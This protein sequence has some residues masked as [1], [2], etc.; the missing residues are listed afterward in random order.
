MADSFNV[1]EADLAFI[2]KQIKVSEAETDAVM[3]GAPADEALRAI[4]GPNAAILPAGLRHVDGS[5]NNLLPG[6]S[7]LGAADTVL[8][9]LA[10]PSYITDTGSAPF[11]PVSNTNYAAPGNVVDSAPRTISNLIADQTVNNPAAVAAWQALNPGE[12]LNSDPAIANQQLSTIK[13]LSPDIGLSPSFN[14][15]MTLFG[16][17][18][19]HGLDL[20]TKGGNG[21]VFVPL[22][23]DDPLYVPGG[24]NFMALT[25]ATPAP[26][27]PT[28]TVNTTT[29]WIDQ[30]QTYTSHPSHQV[31]LREYR[32]SADADGDGIPDSRAVSTGKLLDGAT[33]GIAT[34]AETKAQ[35]LKFL[36][37]RLTDADVLN[38]PLLRTDAYGNFIPGPNG[39][40]QIATPTGF[41]EGSAAGT[42]V[43]ANAFRTGHAFLDD[44]AHTAVPVLVGGVLQSDADTVASNPVPVNAQGR[45]TQYDNELLDAHFITGDGR[46]NENIGLTAVHTVFHS[47]HN[48]L[49]DAN[50][51]TLIAAART[52]NQESLALLNEYLAVD[53][54]AVPA[55]ASTLVWDGA[56]LFQAAKFVT[57]MQYQ[58]LVFEEFARKVQPNVN[59][60]VFTNTPDIDPSI[61]AE[62]AH[63]VYRFGHSMLTDTV[64]RMD[65]DMT[66]DDILLFDAFLNPLEF[67]ASGADASEAAG[68][69]VRGMTRQ[70]GNE[71]DEFVVNALRNQ[72]VGLP[73]DLAALNI[74][75]GRELGVPSLN[76][77]RAKMYE[78]TGQDQ[79]KPYV[80]WLDYA[81]NIKNPL[82][83]VN[84]IAAYGTHGS[85]TSATTLEAKRDAATLLV[86]GDFDVDGDGAPETAPTDRLDFLN[87][88]GT[89]A[90]PAGG[91]TTTGLNAVDFWIGGLAE[92][93]MEFGGML[94]PTFNF[95]FE[96]QME[97]LQNGDRFYYLSRLQ[98]TNMLNQL[99][100]N[101]FAGLVMRNTDL[102]DG[103]ASHLPGNLFDT[104]DLILEID[105]SKQIGADPV[106]D[107][108]V[109][110][111]IN[112]KVV[113]RDPGADVDGDGRADGG[114][115]KFTGGEHVVLGGTEGNDTLIGDKGI[116]A[117]WGDGGDDYLNARSESDQVFGGDG[118][119]VIEDP[120][121]DDLLRG[122]NGNDVIS[123]GAG[124][125]ILFGGAGKDFVV[126]GAETGEVFAGEGDDF[127]IGGNAPDVLMGN[128]GDDWIQGGDGPDGLSGE[129]S[130][131]FFN[132]PIIG[133]DVLNGEGNDTDYD[134]ESGDDIMFQGPGVQRSNG[135]FGFDWAIHKGDP[136]AADSDLG[137]RI[138]A[139]QPDFILR[140]RFDSVE[141]LSG[142][143]LN[144]TL[145]GTNFPIGVVDAVGG[146]V[147]DVG[148]ESRLTQAGVDRISGLQA[149]VG[150]M[151]LADP[152]AV[153]FD[154]SNGG[155]IIL[156]GDGS[157]TIRGNAGDD[158]LDGDA[159]LNARISVRANKDGT[160]AELFS[161]DSMRDLQPRM[162]TREINPGQLKIVREILHGDGS[163][164][165]D[166]AVFR[167]N[168]S[169]YTITSLGDES[170]TV[171]H[172]NPVL[173]GNAL[174]D[175]T[176]TLRNIERARFADQTVT[177]INRAATGSP[178][179][180]DITPTEGQALTASLAGIADVDGLPLPGGFQYRWQA[181]LDGTT[182]TN[183]AGAANA[184]FTPAQAQVNQQ[185]RLVVSFTDG[186]G[187]AETVISAPTAIVGDRFNGGSGND[188]PILT[189]G[190]DNAFGNGGDDSLVG[191][192]GADTLQGGAGADTLLG[193][194]GSDSLDGG[195]GQDSMVGGAGD[196]LYRVDQSNDL[197]V[198]A[199]GGGLDTVSASTNYGLSAE[200]EDLVLTGASAI[201]GAGNGLANRLTGNGANNALFGQGG[202]D[203][204]D[205]AGGDDNLFGGDGSDSLLG[206]E[207]ADTLQGGAG[208]D[209]LLGG[210]GSDSLDGGSGQDSMVG[211]AGDDLYRVDQSND[212]VVEAAGGGLD[213]VSASTNYGLS[214]EVEDLVLTGASAINGAGNGLAN[215]LTGNGANNALFGQGGADT[216]DGAGGDDNLFGGDGDDIF[217]FGAG[218]G[219]D[220][221]SGFDANATG[222]QDLLD[223]SGL[224]VTAANFTALVA[225]TDIGSDTRVTYN[226]AGGGT[227]VLLGVADATTVDTSD[228]ILLA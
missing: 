136:N 160:G 53:V 26:G 34:W 166:V 122:E 186:G 38:V 210:S 151:A 95:V 187:A 118:D 144:D 3:S 212:L 30:N 211:G 139:T 84:F 135:M 55:D 7:L 190:A 40:A 223:F 134:G 137:I 83:I 126:V 35:A 217:V 24:P 197:V 226:G 65:A 113:R 39:Y 182:W 172:V 64:A 117:L 222:G 92:A 18:F 155:D 193:G 152:N 204:L 45:N 147:V 206:G 219:N 9:R 15:W 80:S 121:G 49:V 161:V 28:E 146:G 23:P 130:E 154:P 48:R 192:E 185:L 21:T 93:K 20:I 19:D 194:S 57:E 32:F 100:P 150:G 67:N 14:G 149:I 66:S 125:D 183:I 143:K 104:P 6:G 128:E 174:D 52:G 189:A 47:E 179:V 227:V 60:F 220:R 27:Q 107:T 228:F 162:L 216:L 50:K 41:V 62:F 31:F 68:A 116:D 218:S 109:L 86:F 195:S 181:S 25:R 188:N 71:I 97:Q 170:F 77:F 184:S 156:G 196:D 142:W 205:G 46:G 42:P 177:L 112:P 37:I 76:D 119:D 127:V 75:R 145:T 167:G 1:N 11:G 120:F 36:G 51:A 169:E 2:L 56:R 202:A 163:D 168:R 221:I 89:W 74:A 59:P 106:Q 43:P 224:G 33:G 199:A 178:T 85:I 175:G 124:L 213:T 10:P 101:T 141:G 158:I 54:A 103:D 13:N 131:L 159:W 132:S 17:F 108:A 148:A 90:T 110:E 214:A 153:V 94:G 44:I 105:R 173:V 225:I 8:P 61:V 88:T 157:D 138:F 69:I 98:G 115:L 5:N 79:L 201:N 63:T 22:Q 207:G 208:A 133:H 123:G 165:T 198:E 171:A 82:S 176:D 180:S 200:V 81:Q 12:T 191:G 164:D 114:Y 70:A 29:S 16:Q 111:A 78:A 72:L 96:T 91:R 73:L 215:R 87:S 102:G 58:H 4:I 129:N 209:T 99:E 140:D 203:T